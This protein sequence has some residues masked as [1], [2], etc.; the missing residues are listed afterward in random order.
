MRGGKT[1]PRG[2]REGATRGASYRV[3]RRWCPDGSPCSS[4]LGQLQARTKRPRRVNTK[5]T[6]PD[7]HSQA[8]LASHL[9]SP[10]AAP[11]QRTRPGHQGMKGTSRGL[12]SS[13]P[14][15]LG[16]S[17]HFPISTPKVFEYTHINAK[18]TMPRPAG[19][20]ET[21]SQHTV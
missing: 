2:G 16:L 17:F 14:C 4:R 12:V 10:S 6:H 15:F 9:L 1:D 3:A 20:P 11:K 5:T 7:G 18:R 13:L 21:I 19:P 8:E